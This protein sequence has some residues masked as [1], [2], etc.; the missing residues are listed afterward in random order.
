MDQFL[1]EVRIFA[2]N[3]APRSWA[4][5]GGQL[6]AIQTNTALFSILGT[7]YGGD[8]RTT[9]GLP[10]LQGQVPVGQGQGPGLS[11]WTIGQP[12]GSEMVT[13]LPNQ[14]GPH[15]HNVNCFNAEGTDSV[16]ANTVLASSGT[17]SR[18]NLVYNSALGT[19]KAMNPQQ[20]GLI[21]GNQSHNNISPYLSLNYCI[22]LEGVYPQRQ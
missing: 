17:D 3:F 9:F 19:P 2:C 15:T 5:C 12:G 16:P 22:A 4:F 6:L 11:P 8:G 21:G 10:N 20:L 7:M 13:L 18:G 14:A 1:G